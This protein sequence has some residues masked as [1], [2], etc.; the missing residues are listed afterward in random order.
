MVVKPSTHSFWSTLVGKRAT[1]YATGPG[2]IQGS[3]DL[4]VMIDGLPHQGVNAH[5]FEPVVEE[6]V[7]LT[8]GMTIQQRAAALKGQVVTITQHSV[9][10]S[11]NCALDDMDESGL[12]LMGGRLKIAWADVKA[13]EPMGAIPGAP[14]TKE[15]K[16]AAKEAAKAA[17]LAA[18]EAEKAA[19]KIAPT[20]PPVLFAAQE[21]A[22]AEQQSLPGTEAI[23][24]INPATAL[25]HAIEAIS[26][27]LNG[28]KV[29]RKVLE[30]VLPLL[31]MAQT[32]QANLEVGNYVGAAT[33]T[34]APK[35]P[36]FSQPEALNAL[37]AAKQAFDK[38][39]DM[40][41]KA[42]V[43]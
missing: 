5:R 19:A 27:A 23:A 34:G 1:V 39:H 26:V 43:F 25:Y 22:K 17:K 14:P 9:F 29:T 40:V 18:K 10:S 24:A 3:T 42:W 20:S 12:V 7:D 11:T 8:A 15:Q 35:P 32:H 33:P 6:T 37:E 31:Q 28:G 16:A 36:L 2:E 30:G 13:I 21:A 41:V 38:A 4:S